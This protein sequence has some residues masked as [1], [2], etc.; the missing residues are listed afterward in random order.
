EPD[1]VAELGRRLRKS[2]PS[3]LALFCSYR[4]P[5]QQQLSAALAAGDATSR[6]IEEQIV[7]PRLR[8]GLI[9][10]RLKPATPIDASSAIVAHQY[11]VHPYPAWIAEPAAPPMLPPAVLEA[12]GPGGSEVVRSVLVAGCG[13]GQQAFAAASAWPRASILAIDLSRTSLAYAIDKAD[14]F[15][16]CR[17]QFALADLHSADSFGRFDVIEA[18]GVLHHLANPQLGLTALANALNERGLI[19]I[20]LYS[21]AARQELA[22]IRQRYGRDVAVSDEEV[23][24]FRSWALTRHDFPDF[25]YAPDFYSLGGCRD[26]FFHVR[27]RSYT[28]EEIA[29]L[30]DLSGLRLVA[31]QPPPRAQRRL[32][33]SMPGPTDLAGWSA[34][35]RSHPKLFINM[36]ELWVQRVGNE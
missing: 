10:K 7:Q 33:S 22:E 18:F 6:L 17:I 27:E 24:R 25:L 3:A 11:E 13:T 2:D 29:T 31:L 36:Y 4:S 14:S 23:R 35:E 16:H 15:P 8:Q 26:L 32:G 9:A 5:Q 1:L 30:L 20:G 28:L 12:L 19:G 34:A 21:A